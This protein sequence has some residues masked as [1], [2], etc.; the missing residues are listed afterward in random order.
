MSKIITTHIC[1]PIP[2][3][4]HDWCAYY[5]GQEETGDYGYGAT[6][7]AAIADLKVNYDDPDPEPDESFMFA[8]RRYRDPDQARDDM[9]DHMMQDFDDGTDYE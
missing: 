3:R 5:D 1:P 4:D 7:Q 2:Y 9:Q 8:G 6:E